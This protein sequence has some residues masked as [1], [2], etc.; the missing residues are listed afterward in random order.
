MAIVGNSELTKPPLS[1]LVLNDGM[2]GFKLSQLP[3]DICH[4]R[5]A[6]ISKFVVTTAPG[7]KI[8]HDQEVTSMQL[9]RRLRFSTRRRRAIIGAVRQEFPDVR[10]CR[11]PGN[12]KGRRL[13]RVAFCQLRFKT[14][15]ELVEGADII[16]V[17]ATALEWL[18][19]QEAID[20][21]EEM[22]SDHQDIVQLGISLTEK[23]Q[24]T[25]LLF[26]LKD[27]TAWRAFGA[28]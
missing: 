25:V 6:N 11:L 7:E 23:E 28:T 24:W 21:F 1:S 10:I 19:I 2:P 8:P 17:C 13:T 14:A 26:H 3:S 4:I 5:M 22:G 15:E 12:P 20:N 27:T 16:L 9:T 18:H